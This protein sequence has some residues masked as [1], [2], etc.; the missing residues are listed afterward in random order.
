[1]NSLVKCRL[2]DAGYLP[3]FREEL[4]RVTKTTVIGTECLGLR[5]S[6][7]QFC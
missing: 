5:I 2:S 6:V 4:C 1:G 7:N 3:K